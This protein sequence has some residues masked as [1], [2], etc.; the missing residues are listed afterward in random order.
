MACI[1]LDA[2]YTVDPEPSGVA[3]YSR[4][5][6]EALASTDAQHRF[7]L[8]Y[9]LSRFGQRKEFL[10]PTK[11]PGARGPYFS[12]RMYQEYLT[13]WLPWQARLFHSLA[14]RPPAFHFEKEV[15][16]IFDIFP[17][18]GKDYSTPD[19]Q[20]K[21]AALLREAVARAAR[22]IT[23]SE[24]TA[25]QLVKHLETPREKIRVISAGVDFPTIVLDGA[26][27]AK[28]RERWV[29][30][31]NEMVLS[32]GA[33]Q[34]RKNTLNA[35]R[36]LQ[37]LPSNYRMVWAGGNG[38][39]SEAIHEFI[40]REGLASR[41]VTPGYVSADRLPELYQAASIF[42]FPSFEEGFG[43]PILEAMTHGVPVVAANASSLPELGG[44]AV[45]YADPNDPGQIA[46]QVR[47]VIEDVSLRQ[48]M[49]VS[50]EAR[51]REFSWSK[52]AEA[53]LGVYEELLA[54]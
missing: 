27:R 24:Y 10:R 30:Q 18:T 54:K 14:Q 25:G 44:E 43:F 20:R 16:T 34:T 39:G 5:L 8:C 48:Q 47:R 1:A 40:R 51:A 37:S 22:V 49:I 53:T 33:L 11:P 42:L 41:V 31:G 38:H 50:G 2:T 26:E 21:F 9:R 28:E 52:A 19:F 36:A 4:R 15:V 23:L 13:F 12:I 29:G 3:V 17:I 32:V 6:I 45:L 46:S 35:L 7:L